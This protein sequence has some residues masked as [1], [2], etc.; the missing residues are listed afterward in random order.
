MQIRRRQ[1]HAYRKHTL[2]EAIADKKNDLSINQR[3]LASTGDLRNLT[4]SNK[5]LTENKTGSLVLR[6]SMATRSVGAFTGLGF[7]L[8]RSVGPG[9]HL[10]KMRACVG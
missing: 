10:P 4:E 9:S 5:Y 8:L 2:E 1:V 7:K 3:A 6:A